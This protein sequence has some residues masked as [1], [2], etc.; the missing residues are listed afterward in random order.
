MNANRISHKVAQWIEREQLFTKD[1]PLLLAISGGKDS[2]AL[3][4]ILKEL[5]YSFV[6]AHM[7]FQLRGTDSDGD[8]AFVRALALQLD[9]V[10]HVQRVDTKMDAMQGESTQ[11]AARR[12][13]YS[14][15]E[16]IARSKGYSVIVT[17]HTAN[18]NAETILF[19]LSQGTGLKGLVGI[20][21]KN[22]LI[23]RPLLCLSTDDVLEYLTENG[24]EYREDRSNA[25]DA[26]KR[27]YIRHHVVPTLQEVNHHLVENLFSHSARFRGISGYYHEK[28][29]ADKMKYWNPTSYG[30]W[31]LSLSFFSEERFAQNMLIEWLRPFSFS[32]ADLASIVDS[33]T[34]AHV[35]NTSKSHLLVKERAHLTLVT[36]ISEAPIGST[37]GA[38][39]PGSISTEQGSLSWEII[40]SLE[41]EDLRAQNHAYLD[42]EQLSST[43]LTLANAKDGDRIR[44][45]G[46]KGSQL[47]SDYAV[48]AKLGY[49]E[50]K[51]LLTLS[52]GDRIAWI[53]S[54]RSSDLHKVT[55]HSKRILK[56]TWS[57]K[58][59]SPFP[60]T[61]SI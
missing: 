45:Y 43:Q 24:I 40:H 7:N 59:K 36:A 2:V 49:E 57:K 61:E 12:L 29:E 38:A 1:A 28:L 11:M 53:V 54:H 25:S 46:M 26:Y 52:D 4:Y 17:A 23:R 31:Q 8:E 15:F 55:S 22:D 56:L 34:G 20:P 14:W 33:Q 3:A 47:L 39:E 16:N 9:I 5:G 51:Q 42:M 21:V 37:I 30:N 13:R 60:F 18:D 6:L 58:T 35:C 10:C 41:H 32:N 27:N 44:P 50:K 48:N 19:N